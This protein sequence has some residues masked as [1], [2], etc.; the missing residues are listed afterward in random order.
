M[1][2][3]HTLVTHYLVNDTFV[4]FI[5]CRLLISAEFRIQNFDFLHKDLKTNLNCG[6]VCQLRKQILS[7]LNTLEN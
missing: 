6:F 4:L 7:K 2:T 3:R 1:C 5:L